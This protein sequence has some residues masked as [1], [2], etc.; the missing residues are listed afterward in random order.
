VDLGGA[1]GAVGEIAGADAGDELG[2]ALDSPGDINGDGRPDL[3]I[4]APFLNSPTGVDRIDNGAAYVIYGGRGPLNLD[5]SHLR[6]R[7][8]VVWGASNSDEAGSAIAATDV[9]GD[10]HPDL[11]VGAPF[12]QNPFGSMPSV[13]GAVYA[14]LG[15]GRP[16]LRYSPDV[17]TGHVGRPIRPLTPKLTATGAHTFAITP[18]LPAGVR[19]NGTT[20]RI[21]G[22]PRHR[23]RL[24][25]YVIEMSDSS[26]VA[27]ATV[28]LAVT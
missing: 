24:R 11:L 1:G 14:V 16:S 17:E 13:G 25:T 27:E 15:W 19:L 5:L 20:G 18:R 8:L 12:A 6:S 10:R 22:T 2:Y 26:G 23:A 9:N 7:G 28:R 21:T 4:G 3:A